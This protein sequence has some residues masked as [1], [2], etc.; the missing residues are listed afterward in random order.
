MF[1]HVP[2]VGAVKMSVMQIIEVTFVFD[3]S[4]PAARTM[5]MGVLIVRFVVAHLSWL[6]PSR[7]FSSMNVIPIDCKLIFGRMRE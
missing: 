6:L 7:G 1:V 3:G 4:V 2:L 5:Y